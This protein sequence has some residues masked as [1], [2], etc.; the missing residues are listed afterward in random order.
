MGFALN[1]A[2]ARQFVSHGFFLVNGRRVNIPSFLVK[3][4]DVVEVAEAKRQ[5]LY[6]EESLSK[7]EHRGLPEWVEL[8]APSRKGRV[9]HVPSRG[10]IPLDV[11]E[12][13]IVE[14]Y[15]K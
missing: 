14:L 13:L 9:L 3:P 10:E 7:A 5:H 8:D 1:R 15:S 6:I 11:R 2:Q 4:G 12:Q